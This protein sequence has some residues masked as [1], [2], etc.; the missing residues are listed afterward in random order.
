GMLGGVLAVPVGATHVRLVSPPYALSAP[1]PT[2]RDTA[3]VR[4]DVPVVPTPT[5]LHGAPVRFVTRRAWVDGTALA[6][7]LAGTAVSVHYK[8]QADRLFADY[9][10]TGNPLLRPD[11]EALDRK[12]A[13]ALGVGMVGLTVFT[14][15]LALR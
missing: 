9:E 15:R 8:F 14:V 4:L 2:N 1:L 11:I 6:V 10:Q 12:A 3:L 5:V 13:F 7:A